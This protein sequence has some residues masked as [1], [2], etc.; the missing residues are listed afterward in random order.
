MDLASSS[1]YNI[2]SNMIAKIC[3]LNIYIERCVII[4]IYICII[5][6]LESSLYSILYHLIINL[7]GH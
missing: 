5:I 4:Y 2:L 3:L 1:N 6:S 7:R